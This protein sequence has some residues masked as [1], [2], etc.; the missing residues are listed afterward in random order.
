[1]INAKPNPK[2]LGF[3]AGNKKASRL[4]EVTWRRGRGADYFFVLNMS[5]ASMELPFDLTGVAGSGVIHGENRTLRPN[6]AG[7]YKDTF[8]P[9]EMHVYKFA[10][11]LDGVAASKRSRSIVAVPEPRVM[12]L[13][14]AFGALLLRRRAER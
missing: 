4:L 12:G 14:A 6:S 2:T 9:W 5:S 13:A 8:A 11:P 3:V 10:H 1:V 7:T